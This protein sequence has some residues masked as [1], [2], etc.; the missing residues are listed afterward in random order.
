[1]TTA[2]WTIGILALIC[3]GL[4]GFAY[5]SRHGSTGDEGIAEAVLAVLSLSGAGVFSVLWAI[6]FLIHIWPTHG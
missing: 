6:L 4:A 5:F 3:L 2:L 1:M